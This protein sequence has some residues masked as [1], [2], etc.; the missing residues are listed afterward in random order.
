M[1]KKLKPYGLHHAL[2]VFIISWVLCLIF[3]PDVGMAA[4]I[5]GAGRYE[6]REHKE[7][8]LRGLRTF[9]PSTWSLN[10]FEWA[11]FLTVWALSAFNVFIMSGM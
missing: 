1:I 7:A 10:K 4:A 2:P 5:Y 6:G 8:E 9:K 11:D 3:N